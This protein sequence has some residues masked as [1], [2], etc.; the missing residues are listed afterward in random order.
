MGMMTMMMDNNFD[1]GDGDHNDS[2]KNGR[3]MCWLMMIMCSNGDGSN[4]LMTVMMI[5][6]WMDS[7]FTNDNYNDEQICKCEIHS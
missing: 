2:D 4:S 3:G 1:V 7:I 5:L 6:C